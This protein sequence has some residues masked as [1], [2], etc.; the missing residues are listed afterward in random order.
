[1]TLSKYLLAVSTGGSPD[2]ETYTLGSTGGLTAQASATT[3]TDPSL[4]IALAL[5]H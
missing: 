2:L 1:M 3:Q 4:P 5:T